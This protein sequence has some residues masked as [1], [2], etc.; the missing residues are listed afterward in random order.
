MSKIAIVTDSTA[1][2]PKELAEKYRIRTVPLR[3]HWG[4]DTYRDGIDIKTV[5]F[6]ERLKTDPVT[7]TTAAPSIGDFQKV[8]EEALESAEAVVSIHIAALLSATLQSA[9]Q[10][11]VLLPGKSIELIDSGST[12]MAMGYMVLAAARAVEAGASLGEVLAA[13]RRLIAAARITFT[14]DTLEYLRRGGRIGAAQAFVGNLMDVKP[15]LDLRDGRVE[16]LERVRTKKKAVARIVDI[17]AQHAESQ[18]N[19][20]V[21]LAAV[22]ALVPDEAAA[23]LD[24]A[25][26][27]MNVVET[28]TTDFS[29]TIA[30]HSGPGT[31]GLVYTL[32]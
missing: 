22:H 10:A 17:I 23:L 19:A 27:R 26:A 24:M 21:R 16:P 18:N 8:Y 30:T 32:A 14:V 15:I 5:D 6:Y 13:A 31:L 20:P 12:S 3:V 25:V 1:Y 7:P 29:P 11:K 9:E 28:V 2:I 4:S